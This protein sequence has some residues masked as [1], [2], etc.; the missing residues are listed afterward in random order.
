M[1]AKHNAAAYAVRT[2]AYRPKVVKDKRK[3]RVKRS[4]RRR[5]TLLDYIGWQTK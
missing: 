5:I 4:E 1:P 2:A 3:K